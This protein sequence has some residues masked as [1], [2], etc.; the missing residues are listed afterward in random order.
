MNREHERIKNEVTLLALGITPDIPVTA[1]VDH[2]AAC[3]ECRQLMRDVYETAGRIPE[4]LPDIDAPA[5]VRE[6]I[7][8]RVRE[9]ESAGTGDEMA[10]QPTNHHR[11]VRQATT[12]SVHRPRRLPDRLPR[13]VAFAAVVLLLFV[14]N[15]AW[16]WRSRTTDDVL[17]T[18]RAR[19]ESDLNWLR[20]AEYLLVRGEPPA[21]SGSLHVPNG[22]DLAPS[23][24]AALYYTTADNGYLLVRADGLKELTPHSVWLHRDGHRQHLG[25]F[26]STATG[27]GSY[28]YVGKPAEWG[29]LTD[30]GVVI[31][32]QD[33]TLGHVVLIGTLQKRSDPYR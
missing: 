31:D 10:P 26:T 21:Y 6:S 24:Q 18:V 5:P 30:D 9:D 27:V 8:R 13:V 25:D 20:S 1:V 32:M 23:G 33:E 2:A 7:L 16:L 22:A 17:A 4:T 3:A 15:F 11:P 14:S 28:V 29:G 12:P 19:Y